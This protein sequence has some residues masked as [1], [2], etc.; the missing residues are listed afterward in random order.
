MSRVGLA[1][2]AFAATFL[3]PASHAA[4][5]PPFETPALTAKLITAED[6]IAPGAETL[7]A[8]LVLDLNEGWK[9]YW[10]SPG[11][12][13]L[14][15]QVDWNASGNV[16]SAEFL[17][18]APT[19]FRAFGIENFGYED[20][21][22]HP[23]RITLQE[24][25]RPV[26]LRADV[27]LLACS[28]VCVPV[29]FDL[30]LS[31]PEG[32]G[33][34][35][36]AAATIG[37]WAARIPL[38]AESSD[39][40]LRSAAIAEGEALIVEAVRASGWL[41]PDVFPEHGEGTAF[42]APDIR[43]SPDRSVLWASLPVL[44]MARGRASLDLTIT[45]GEFAVAFQ[46]VALVAGA[47]APP[48]D[49]EGPSRSWS[50][51]GWLTLFAFGGGLIL[52]AMPCVL[53]V[54]SI[55][56]SSAL[57]ATSASGARIRAG[58]LA[59]AA[60]TVAF[61]WALAALV[62]TLQSLGYAF[63]WGTQFQNPYFL[64][65]LA[66]V[67][68]LFAA[69]S[70]GAFEIDLPAPL[71][72]RIGGLGKDGYAG[73]FATGAFAAILATPCSAPLLGSAVAFALTGSP[74]EVMV[75]FT[76]MGLGLALPYLIVAARPGLVAMLPRPGSWMIGLRVILGLLLAG[77][78]TWLLWV[79]AGVG[80]QVLAL[81]VS[82]LLLLIIG[83]FVLAHRRRR[84]AGP[85]AVTAAV[86]VAAMLASPAAL[87]SEA[88]EVAAGEVIEWVTL[89]RGDIARHVSRGRVVFVDVTADWC[90]TCK[91]N[92]ALVLERSPIVDRLADATVIAM[93]ADWTRPDP[94]IAAYLEANGRFGIPFNAVYGP[95]APD[96][97]L[98]SELLTPGAVVEALNRAGGG[99]AATSTDRSAAA[100]G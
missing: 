55:K 12:V 7:S 11:E 53:P 61:M 83:T 38:P 45:D 46:D 86:L 60:G 15:P 72:T 74:F 48:Y 95:A 36:D 59:T 40:A 9:T 6:G 5:S 8:A 50:A 31:I 57:K 2:I 93:Q 76:A 73:D 63:G 75:I 51:L 44:A 21:V 22:V 32:A 3:G 99:Q 37:A 88:R 80:S 49:L 82:G 87:R 71:A 67:I 18:P 26:E 16:A 27:S 54:L 92:K 90:L 96:G 97:I 35:R 24:P 33:V 25:G 65:A 56:L 64:T 84:S 69:S 13:G 30:A 34:D 47:A 68:G 100:G 85:A 98:L 77:T 19:R 17:W 52:N 41:A 91:A 66:L 42:G 70:L 14:P 1:A 28:N 4:G 79:L 23:V 78:A 20:A 10:R 39:V 89:D 43:L 81:A 58:F 62:V 29:R 94:R